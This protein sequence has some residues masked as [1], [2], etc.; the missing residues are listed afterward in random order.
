MLLAFTYDAAAVLTMGT[1]PG[2]TYVIDP[3]T[4]SALP[5]Y[6]QVGSTYNANVTSQKTISG[7]SM[8]ISASD[9]GVLTLSILGSTQV[10]NVIVKRTVGNI[11]A[12]QILKVTFIS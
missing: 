5:T 3:G 2:D 1:F 9:F 4:L 12:Y 11:A 7:S 8:S 6:S 10:R